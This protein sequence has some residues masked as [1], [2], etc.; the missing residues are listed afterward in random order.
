[1]AR[2][3]RHLDCCPNSTPIK[4]LV[5]MQSDMMTVVQYWFECPLHKSLRAGRNDQAQF[6]ESLKSM[7]AREAV[8]ARVKE[9]L[10]LN[11]DHPGVPFANLDDGGVSVISGVTGQ[12][13]TALRN[14]AST[15]LLSKPM[16]FG[17]TLTVE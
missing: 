4:C 11:K 9:L 3:Y 8:R 12:Q 10:A 17:K 15:I 13:R 5:E 14:A 16:G 7:Y 2:Y 1:M 6:N